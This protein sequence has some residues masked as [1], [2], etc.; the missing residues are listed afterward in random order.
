MKTAVRPD[1][2]PC[3]YRAST[4]TVLRTFR[5]AT[6]AQLSEGHDWY[7]QAHDL[8]AQ[9][10][11][12][13]PRR[14]AGV[15]AALSPRV[16]WPRNVELARR[17]YAEGRASGV[18]GTSC[19]AADA[20]LGGAHPLDVLRGPKTRAFFTLIDDPHHPSM[21][22][23][24]RHGIDVAVGRKLPEA[25]RSAWFPLAR[26]GLYEEFAACYRRAALIADVRPSQMQAV[27]WLAWRAAT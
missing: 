12:H 8:A 16:A 18:L 9:L 5:A 23:V 7:D 21:V 26:R 22:C 15:L 10:D 2:G 19:R 13:D 27:T 20:I 24:D 11:P 25:Q 6:A 17:A 14:A 4:R 1:V 3:R